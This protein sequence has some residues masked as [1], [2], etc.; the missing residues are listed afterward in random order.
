MFS[1][2]LC[3]RNSLADS[4]VSDSSMDGVGAVE[5]HPLVLL[6]TVDG[7]TVLLACRLIGLS[8][9]PVGVGEGLTTGVVE[10][11]LNVKIIAANPVRCQTVWN[12]VS[13]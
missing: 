11:S 3:G 10:G 8:L 5:S 12:P 7:N 6:G 4:V 1:D 9:H 13:C 2:L